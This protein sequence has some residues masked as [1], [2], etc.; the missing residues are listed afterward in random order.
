MRDLCNIV[1]F[2]YKNCVFVKVIHLQYLPVV[3]LF[4]GCCL[5]WKTTCYYNRVVRRNKMAVS[6]A[7]ILLLFSKVKGTILRNVFTYY[8]RVGH[9]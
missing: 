9:K 8:D 5:N 4:A 7:Q 6:L 1:I 3:S 2:N